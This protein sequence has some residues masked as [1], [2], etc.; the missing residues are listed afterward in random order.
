MST[1]NAHLQPIVSAYK[2]KI[3]FLADPTFFNHLAFL[4]LRDDFQNHVSTSRALRQIQE[5]FQSP[6]S[7]KKE[8]FKRSKYGF[9][10]QRINQQFGKPFGRKKPK[11]PF[12]NQSAF[13]QP[14]GWL[15]I[16]IFN[17]MREFPKPVFNQ[18]LIRPWESAMIQT[19]WNYLASLPMS[20]YNLLRVLPEPILNQKWVFSKV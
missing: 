20:I 5:Y 4:N 14:L 16:K 13:L 7:T 10:Q 2:N 8:N 11:M 6:F 17:P 9:L 15:P 12:F 19:F 3:K 1:S 18:N